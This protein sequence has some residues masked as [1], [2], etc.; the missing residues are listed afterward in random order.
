MW[1]A[2]QPHVPFLDAMHG[3]INSATLVG[4]AWATW[5]I[6]LL[7]LFGIWKHGLHRVPPRYS[8]LLWTLV[9]PPGVYACLPRTASRLP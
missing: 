8:P 6:P 7:I 2:A 9:F 1:N 5:W 4:W 3:F